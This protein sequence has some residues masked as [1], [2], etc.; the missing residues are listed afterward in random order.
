MS[1]YDSYS[2][3][4]NE[5]LPVIPSHW[6]LSTL[7]R[8]FDV[9]LGKMLCPKPLDATYSLEEYYC[10]GDVHFDGVNTCDLK[11]MWFS[12]DEKS[13]YCVQSK[14]LLIVEGGAGA[15]GCSVVSDC[16]KD[17][18]IQNSILIA[19]HPS[20]STVYLKYLVETLVRKGYIVIVSSF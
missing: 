7:G 17:R 11:K 20:N 3:T 9:I 8:H 10:A 4:G 5:W 19:R 1:K 2:Q 16:E 14:D 18:Y 6:R 15:G 12:Q 13:K